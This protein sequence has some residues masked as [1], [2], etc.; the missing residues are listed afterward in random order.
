MAV[1]WGA[2][3]QPTLSAPLYDPHL[4]LP[5]LSAPPDPR[6]H[7]YLPLLTPPVSLPSSSL[8]KQELTLGAAFLPLSHQV[9]A[10]LAGPQGLRSPSSQRVH[11]QLPPSL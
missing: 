5:H 4:P 9:A 1:S 11:P 8:L 6:P 2:L 7:L 3:P 10:P